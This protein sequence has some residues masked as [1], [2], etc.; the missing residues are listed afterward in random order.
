MRYELHNLDGTGQRRCQVFDMVTQAPD[1]WSAV[2]GVACPAAN[3]AGT[4]RWSE[5]GYVPG[6]RI[7][8]QCGRHYLAGGG[9]QRPTLIRVGHRRSKVGAR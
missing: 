1:Y 2:T 6:Y 5:A 8:D 7:C 9:C 3:C 4:V